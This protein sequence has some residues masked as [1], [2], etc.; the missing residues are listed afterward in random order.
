MDSSS[1][2]LK[3]IHNTQ[4]LGQH[5][6]SEAASSQISSSIAPAAEE[7]EILVQISP[8]SSLERDQYIC[9]LASLSQLTQPSQ[10]QRTDP[11]IGESSPPA[12]SSSASSPIVVRDQGGTIPDSQSIFDSSSYKPT[13]TKSPT[14]SR[15]TQTTEDIDTS[16]GSRLLPKDGSL[17]TTIATSSDPIEDG[18]SPLAIPRRETRAASLLSKSSSSQGSGRILRKARISSVARRLSTTTDSEAAYTPQDLAN[19]ISLL[20][21]EIRPNLDEAYQFEPISQGTTGHGQS[22]NSPVND[23]LGAADR[24][25]DL[26]AVTLAGNN[27]F[28]SAF[29]TQIPYLSD[30]QTRASTPSWPSSVGMSVKY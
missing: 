19:S 20:S 27:T 2:P 3:D 15:A 10:A 12:A 6:E 1:S 16:I 28:E 13:L 14:S 4:E 17:S 24:Q 23:K 25:P 7:A 5:E 18:A 26:P 21:A 22:E 29:Q 30:T 11:G 8:H 9:Y